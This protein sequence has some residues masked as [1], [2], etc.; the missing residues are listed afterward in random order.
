MPAKVP[1]A[2]LLTRQQVPGYIRDK[3]GGP[4][5][6]TDRT[7]GKLACVGGGPE[8][9]K[10]G[11]KVGYLPFRYRPLGRGPRT[12]VQVYF[13][14]NQTRGLERSNDETQRNR[15]ARGL[16]TPPKRRERLPPAGPRPPLAQ[17][18]RSETV[19]AL[20]MHAPLAP[21]RAPLA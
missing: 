14:P 2:V 17:T 3:F 18:S 10:Y 20:R 19:Y 11:R 1:E 4:A 15:R 5:T 6:V 16:T 8:M 7:L 13:R 9:V 12:R 21:A